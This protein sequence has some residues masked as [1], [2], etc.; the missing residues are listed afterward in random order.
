[1]TKSSTLKNKLKFSLCVIIMILQFSGCDQ[2]GSIP[3]DDDYLRMK[4]S[5]N[6]NIPEDKFVNQ[7]SDVME[8]VKKNSGFWANP[9]KNMAN[10]YFFNSNKT[11]PETL[12]PEDKTSLNENFVKSSNNIKNANPYEKLVA[13][14]T[15]TFYGKN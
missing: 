8:N 13:K 4:K 12:L 10:N 5:S 11:E 1:M 3:K 9:R 15:M 7:N 14:L 2:F 6:Y